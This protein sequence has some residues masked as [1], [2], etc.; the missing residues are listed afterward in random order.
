[1]RKIIFL[2]IVIALSINLLAQKASL[3]SVPVQP[4]KWKNVQIVGGGFV[5]GIVFHPKT[6]DIR[7]CRTDMGG[8][9]R[10]DAGL[11]RW[12]SMLDWITYDDNN[13]VGVESI[14]VDPNDPQTVYLSCG[15]YTRSSNGAILYSND[16][17]LTFKRTDMPF[18]MGGNENG[19]GNGERMMVDPANSNIIYLGT[20]LDGLWRS[21]DKAQNWEKVSSFPDVKEIMPEL[22]ANEA[23]RNPWANRP[24]GSGIIF[25]HFDENSAVK[26]KGSAV[27]YV[28]VSLM[29]RE[30]LFVSY[31]HGKS[32]EAVPGQ[33]IGRASCRERV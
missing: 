17:G 2:T 29:N 3:Q 31:D 12:V 16:G 20:R 19:R 15:T 30:N 32:W 24:Q 23:Q 11:Q 21:T 22:P 1:M 13:L 9:Y 28:G 26:G 5:D 27:I 14:A 10:W 7:Y 8:A 6:K 33:Q 4:Y 25:V 18:T